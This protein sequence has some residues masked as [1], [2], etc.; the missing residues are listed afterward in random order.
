MAA[1][2]PQ[3]NPV[4]KEDYDALFAAD[5]AAWR[6]ANGNQVPKVACFL[7][8]SWTTANSSH[9]GWCPTTKALCSAGARRL[10]PNGNR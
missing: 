6:A 8:Q 1:P 9:G 5:V 7:C 10:A 2:A 3:V 4:T